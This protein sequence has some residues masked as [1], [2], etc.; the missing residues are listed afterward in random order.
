MGTQAAPNL[1]MTIID[2][3]TGNPDSGETV[4]IVPYGDTYPTN[5]VILSEIGVTGRYKKETAPA[6]PAVAEGAWKVYVAGAFRGIFLHGGEFIEAHL[7]SSSDPHGVSGA[8]VAITDSGGYFSGSTVEAALQE[9]GASLAGKASSGGTLLLDGSEQAVADGKPKV[10]FLNADLVDGAEPGTGT[11]DIP[12]LH[13]NNVTGFLNTSLLGKRVGSGNDYIPQISTDVT[14]EAGKVHESVLGKKVGAGDDNI[15][16]ISTDASPEAGKVHDTILGKKVGTGDDNIPQIST[17]GSPEAGKVHDTILAKKVGTGDDN[18]PQISTDVSPE[19]GKVHDTIL[20]KEVGTDDDNIPQ[21]TTDSTPDTGK[22]HDSFLGKRSPSQDRIRQDIAAESIQ[23]NQVI[24]K[25]WGYIIGDDSQ[26]ITELI[27]FANSFVFD[28]VPIMVVS[29]L[30]L[31]NSEPTVITDLVISDADPIGIVNHLV[32]G[33][34]FRIVMERETN[35]FLSSRYYG[36]SW[37]AIGT[38][39]GY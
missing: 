28:N 35:N 15:P 39:S 18:I 32:S 5:K 1:V 14:P 20:G 38:K 26:S 37:I 9:I 10:N 16:Q 19:A 22:V 31:S 30:G 13:E 7:A 12:L 34:Q 29:H 6:S 17:D 3:S 24:H 36:Y 33:S 21:I 23:E 2:L 8:Q 4:E 27:T 25:G 11:G